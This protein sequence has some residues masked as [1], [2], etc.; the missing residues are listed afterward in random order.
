M[1]TRVPT[2][3]VIYARTHTH[4]SENFPAPICTKIAAPPRMRALTHTKGLPDTN[5]HLE[6][7]FIKLR[8]I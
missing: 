8:M 2:L 4:V 7:L 3:R 1:S 6:N 5:E